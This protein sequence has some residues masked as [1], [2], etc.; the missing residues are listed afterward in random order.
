MSERTQL[1][2]IVIAVFML[3]AVLELVRRRKLRIGYSLTWLMV[4]VA[5]TV[6]IAVPLLVSFMADLFGIASARSLLFTAGIG[7]ALWILLDHSL[8]LTKLWR[9]DKDVAQEHA[10]LEWRVRQ[11]EQRVN[12]LLVARQDS[13]PRE[14]PALP[15]TRPAPAGRRAEEQSPGGGEAD[16]SAYSRTPKMENGLHEPQA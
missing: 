12:D 5:A 9:Q 6:L 14:W 8:T 2:G 15:R 13:E 11:L 1:V 7:F 4:G 16:G 3:L 10:L